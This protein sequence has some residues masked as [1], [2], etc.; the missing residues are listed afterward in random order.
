MRV[1]SSVTEGE[2]YA[3]Y[4]SP[5]EIRRDISNIKNRISEATAMLN[6]RS[7]VSEIMDEWLLESPQKAITELETV[8][9]DAYDTLEALKSLNEELDM[10][11]DELREAKW[12]A[13]L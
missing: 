13:A 6:I 12:A 2:Y 10:L 8:V 11:R 3:L 9:S 4:R 5:A 7:L 1:L